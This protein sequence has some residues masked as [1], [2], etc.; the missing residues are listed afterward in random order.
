[1]FGFGTNEYP[2]ALRVIDL[3]AQK[4]EL[5]EDLSQ[6]PFAEEEVE[7][8]SFYGDKMLINTQENKIYERM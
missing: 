5:C 2:N 3:K 1:M 7:C 8:C 6:A 4:Y